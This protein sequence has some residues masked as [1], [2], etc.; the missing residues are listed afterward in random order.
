M[1]MGPRMAWYLLVAVLGIA[2][3]V[4]SSIAP[5]KKYREQKQEAQVAKKNV[6]EAERERSELIRRQMSVETAIGREALVRERGYK[7]PT[8]KPIEDK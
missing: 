7:Y 1:S 6:R 4:A 8:E 2:L 5:W 3:G